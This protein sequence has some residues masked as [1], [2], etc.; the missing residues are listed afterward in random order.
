MWLKGGSCWP[1]T[2]LTFSKTYNEIHLSPKHNQPPCTET[3]L[4]LR[5]GSLS[6]PDQDSPLNCTFTCRRYMGLIIHWTDAELSG[7]R[8]NHMW[9]CIQKQECKVIEGC[10]SS[11]LLRLPDYLT[12]LN[13]IGWAT[14]AIWAAIKKKYIVK[15]FKSPINISCTISLSL[16][17]F[18]ET[19]VD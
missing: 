4:S 18:A 1:W 14:C 8:N 13:N 12:C 19:C 5:V 2:I 10:I 16:G 3:H 17:D 9:S 11:L 6:G 7:G 15:W